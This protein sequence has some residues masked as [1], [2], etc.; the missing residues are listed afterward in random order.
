MPTLTTPAVTLA[1]EVSGHGVV[2]S[3]PDRVNRLLRAHLQ[4]A[5]P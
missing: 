4:A 1:H 5:A 3:Q 2:V